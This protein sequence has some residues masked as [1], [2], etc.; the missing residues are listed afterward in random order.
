MK[1]FFSIIACVAM[2]CAPVFVATSCGSDDDS[3]PRKEGMVVNAYYPVDSNT[4]GLSSTSYEAGGDAMKAVQAALH[5][6]EFTTNEAALELLKKTVDTEMA[7]LPNDVR[8]ELKYRSVKMYFSIQKTNP[9][10]EYT[11]DCVSLDAEIPQ[12]KLTVKSV[13]SYAGG[14]NNVSEST[15]NLL[16]EA[17]NKMNAAMSGQIINTTFDK[18]VLEIAALAAKSLPAEMLASIKACPEAQATSDIRYL[19]MFTITYTS[20]YVGH[21]NGEQKYNMRLKDLVE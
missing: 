20:T 11:Y 17:I 12:L 15:R 6:V 10:V 8:Y 19:P 16:T 18:C 2:L 9:L 21:S 5:E 13:E 7:K 1:K 4:S 14:M 3:T